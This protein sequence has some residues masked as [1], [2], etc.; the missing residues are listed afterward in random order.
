VITQELIRRL[1]KQVDEIQPQL[2][3]IRDLRSKML[4]TAAEVKGRRLGE[5]GGCRSRGSARRFQFSEKRAEPFL[6][7][8]QML[9][10][11][12]SGFGVPRW[13]AL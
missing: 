5:D 12:T 2:V 9:E 3:T 7:V 1:D 4:E 8:G 6:V 13:R 11:H 10:K